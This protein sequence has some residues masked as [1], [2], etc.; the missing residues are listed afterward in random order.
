ML[1]HYDF[2][3]LGGGLAS[4]IAAVLLAKDGKRVRAFRETPRPF[5]GW[6]MPSLHLE[7]LLQQLDGRSCLTSATP[8]QVLTEQSRL[9]LHGSLAFEEEL[10]REF[11]GAHESLE[12][13]LQDLQ[14][15]GERLEQIVWAAG[16]LPVV[17]WR[18]RWRFFQK[19]MRLGVSAAALRRPL[20]NHFSSLGDEVGRAAMSVLF[21]GLSLT[22]FARLSMA[23]GALL[24]SSVC[25]G[26]GVSR[27]GLE[28]LL[29]RRYEQYHGEEGD[30]AQVIAL[31]NEG[32]RKAVVLKDGH[33]VTADHYL[34][35]SSEVLSRLPQ[36]WT[37]HAPR[38]PVQRRFATS[39]IQGGISPLLAAEVILGDADPALRLLFT[40]SGERTAV[41][42]D[43]AGTD[44]ITPEEIHRRL[45]DI[46][47]FASFRMEG[48]PNES[49][50]EKVANRVSRT[51]FPGIHALPLKDKLL[52]CNGGDI[53]PSLGTLGEVLI[54]MTVARHL[55]GTAREKKR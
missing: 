33:R 10:R 9:D 34:L 37:K 52:Y 23:E 54:G 8:F 3:I 21:A 48:N 12:S 25:R 18:S 28:E 14:R 20:A 38:H 15:L 31:Q 5:P 53:C 47:P 46:L 30:L 13:K 4:R 19:R 2:I 35:G 51:P 42:I 50:Q 29:R 24:W 45:S 22:P 55:A 16:G 26:E 6:F 27:S 39:A 44:A 7:R 40:S 32:G 43:Q 11:P 36:E 1:Q 41:L 49:T 17:G